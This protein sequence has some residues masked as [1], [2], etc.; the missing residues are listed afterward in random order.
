MKNKLLSTF[1]LCCFTGTSVYAANGDNIS[2]ST[3]F[4]YSTG[5]YGFTTDTSIFE[6]PVIGRYK[7]GL[8]MF[9]LNIP[10]VR[11]SG[12]GGVL[13][14]G[15]RVKAPATSKIT[16]RSGLGDIVASATYSVSPA[17]KGNPDIDLT[18]KV[19]L[20]TANTSLGT[21]END[22]AAQTDLYWHFNRFTPKVALGYEI[23]GSPQDVVMNNVLYAIVGGSYKIAEYTHGGAELWLSEKHSAVTAEQ[24]ELTVY[25]KHKL[26][27]DMNVRGYVLHGFSDGSPDRG[28]GVLVSSNF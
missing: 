12:P 17:N 9:S 26:D 22:Y 2:L 6:V 18:G 28:I 4:E 5:K 13:S 23:M 27:D 7:S 3:G 11:V 25:L 8:W 20:G 16:T 14:S 1:L 19:K 10:Y 21:G 15:I 24:S